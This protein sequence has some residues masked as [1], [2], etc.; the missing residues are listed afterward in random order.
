MSKYYVYYIS[1]L[2]GLPV[3]KRTKVQLN[4]KGLSILKRS[5]K[6]S[7]ITNVQVTHDVSNKGFNADGAIAGALFLGPIGAVAG[8]ISGDKTQVNNYL[9][10]DYIDRETKRLIILAK[11][12][13]FK[14][15]ELIGA[16]SAKQSYQK[17]S[18]SLAASGVKGL[19]KRNVNQLKVPYYAARKIGSILKRK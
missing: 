1:G 11:G 7:S 10:I 5:I 18:L 13:T 12:P 16:I 17:S 4:N 9:L 14:Q 6:W 15:E 3:S 19:H 8:G 2:D